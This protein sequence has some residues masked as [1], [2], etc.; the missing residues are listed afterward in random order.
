MMLL[1]SNVDCQTLGMCGEDPTQR[2]KIEK[3]Q[4]WSVFTQVR[5][6]KLHKNSKS[7]T[8]LGECAWYDTRTCTF[9]NSFKGNKAIFSALEPPSLNSSISLQ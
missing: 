9:Q 1:K 5:L 8:V 6:S 3:Q 4:K 7:S 2:L